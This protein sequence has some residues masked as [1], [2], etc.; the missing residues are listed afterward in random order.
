MDM[1]LYPRSCGRFKN[2]NECTLHAV[3]AVKKEIPVHEEKMRPSHRFEFVLAVTVLACGG[4]GFYGWAQTTSPHCHADGSPPN[5][6]S[7]CWCEPPVVRGEYRNPKHEYEVHVPD[8]LAEILGCSG[9][10]IGFSVSLAHP[11][12]GEGDWGMNQIAVSGADRHPETFKKMIDDWHRR[13]EDSERDPDSDQQLNEP[14]QT[15]LSSLPALRF[16]S[17]RTKPESARI[18]TEQII[19][20]NPDKD[21]VY[22]ITIVT[23]ADQYEKNEKLFKEIVDGFRYVASEHTANQ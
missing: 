13:K 1:E 4:L 5:G 2:K 9:V 14:E 18:I 6:E 3:C 23:P 17:A 7:Q 21:I 19:A 22:S 15:S 10:G 20:N 12:S 16:K 8:G 11:E